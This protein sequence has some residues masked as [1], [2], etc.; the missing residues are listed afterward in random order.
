MKNINELKQK[1]AAAIAGMRAIL[2]KADAL[3]RK[4]NPILAVYGIKCSPNPPTRDRAH[5]GQ[6]C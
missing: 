6:C 5:D 1:R 2:D 4:R 3:R